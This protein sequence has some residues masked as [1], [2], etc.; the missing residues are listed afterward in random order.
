[1]CLV[2]LYWLVPTYSRSKQHGT[3]PPPPCAPTL[4]RPGAPSPTTLTLPGLRCVCGSSAPGSLATDS[5]LGFDFGRAPDPAASPAVR[6]AL[7]PA[8][9]LHPSEQGPGCL[10]RA[11][12]SCRRHPS[13]AGKAGTRAWEA[14]RGEGKRGSCL[15]QRGGGGAQSGWLGVRASL[16][17]QAGV[18]G[19]ADGRGPRTANAAQD[20][21][22]GGGARPHA[23]EATASPGQAPRVLSL[24]WAQFPTWHVRGRA[25]PTFSPGLV[26][27]SQGPAR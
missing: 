27:V 6:A 25:R 14:G 5:G 4:R 19:V 24:P 17:A 12:S 2:P 11:R 10:G 20:S 15:D 18:V 9:S 23:D 21:V 8:G 3:R 16:E 1:M 26:G 22:H 13:P 7:V